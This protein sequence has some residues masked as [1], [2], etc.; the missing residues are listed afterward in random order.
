MQLYQGSADDFI[1]E[2]T[3]NRIALDLSDSFYNY[4]GYNPSNSEKMSWHNSLRAIKDIF[5]NSNL[6]KQGISLEYF[7]PSSSLRLDCM[8]CGRDKN[9]KDKALIIELKQWA[10]CQSCDSENEVITKINGYDKELLHPSAQVKGYKDHLRNFV[11]VFYQKNPILLDSCVYLH[12]YSFEENDPILDEKF[13]NIINDSPMFSENDYDRLSNYIE[14]SVSHGEGMNIL[15]KINKSRKKPSKKLL[16]EA[17]NTIENNSAYVLLDEQQIVFDHVMSL[18]NKGIKAKDKKHVLI[19]KGGP[20]TGKSVIAINLLAELSKIGKWAE[21]VTGSASFTKSYQEAIGG[22]ARDLFKYTNSYVQ[23]VDQIDC[24]IIDEAHRLRERAPVSF[25]NI[26][27]G[28]LQ[29][30]EIIDACR[31]AVFFIDDDQRVKPNE[32]GSSSYIR[33][34]ALSRGCDVWEEEL[35]IQFR[36]SGNDGFVKWIENTLDIRQTANVMLKNEPDYDFK[37]FDNPLAMEDALK[38]KLNQGQTARIV[39][40]YVFPWTTRNKRDEEIPRDVVIG[41]YKRPWNLKRGQRGIPSSNLW[42]YKPEGF[43]Q[44]GCVYSAQ[45]FEFDYMGVIFGNDIVYDFDKGEWIPKRENAYD[46]PNRRVRDDAAYLKLIKDIY[47]VLL[48]RGIKGCYVYFMDKDTERF[49]KTRISKNKSDC[50]A[51]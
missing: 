9:D 8:V 42:A 34:H 33:E 31:V 7:L 17:A 5:V 1:A 40:G 36:C 38:E 2:T 27:S 18:V 35:Q 6:S 11:E 4:F 46:L 15:D 10:S 37:I 47:R 12:N 26:W 14:D 39:S 49:V 32:I 50:H 28:K 48:S 29:I 30:E 19:I 44:I 25:S 24:L 21:Y 13:T 43:N 41:D 16:D 20:G 22:T 45:G 51:I 3:R 23:Q